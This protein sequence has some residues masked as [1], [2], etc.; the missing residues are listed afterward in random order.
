MA[1]P[2]NIPTIIGVADICQYLAQND[3]SK[4]TLFNTPPYD[5]QLSEKIYVE[6]DSLKFLYNNNPTDASIDEVANY[7]WSLC[8]YTAKAYYIY[9]SGNGGTIVP[10]VPDSHLPLPYDFIVNTST[11]FITNGVSSIFINNFIG[12]NI[13]FVR[14]GIVQT[15]TDPMNG[16]TWYTWDRNSGL[17]TLYNDAAITGESF[18]ISPIG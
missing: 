10:I 9:A 4:S 5:R 12:Y 8:V 18:R 17:F 15:T 11:S 1:T 2:Y 14:G 7:V 6:N 3:L 13:E 16:G